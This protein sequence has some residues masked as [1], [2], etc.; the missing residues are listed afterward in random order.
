MDL[1]AI[2]A[3]LANAVKQTPQVLGKSLTVTPYTPVSVNVP[4]F[5]PMEA[6]IHY[7]DVRNTFNRQ[8]VFDINCLLLTAEQAN[9]IGGQQLLDAYLSHPE[10]ANSVKGQIEQDQTLGGLC[11][12]VFVHDI[13]GYRLYTVGTQA[14]YGARFRIQILGG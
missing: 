8:P 11:K 4:H 1:A 14:Y 6:D 13:D 12:S 9:D 5:Y 10:S 7:A 2:R 3:G